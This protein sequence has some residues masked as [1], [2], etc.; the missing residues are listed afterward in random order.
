[1]QKKFLL[2]LFQ[3]HIQIHLILQLILNIQFL[4]PGFVKITVFDVVG[5]QVGI[6]ENS[7]K[8]SGEHKLTWNAENNTSGIYYIQIS[9]GSEVKAQKVVLLK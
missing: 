7:Y 6:I 5:R 1:M 3:K 9:S 8:N 2:Y 4:N